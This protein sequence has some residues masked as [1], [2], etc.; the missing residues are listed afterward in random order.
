VTGQPT[1]GTGSDLCPGFPDQCPYRLT[2]DPNPPHHEGGVRCGCNARQDLKDMAFQLATAT[3]VVD[4]R[5][6]NATLDRYAAQVL[7]DTKNRLRDLHAPVQHMGKTWCGECSIRRRTGPHSEEWVAY[8]PHPCP[9]LDTLENK[10]T[11]P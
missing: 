9:T 1:I 10:E 7:K 5:E 4:P 2:V 11:T 8:I 6:Y 3:G